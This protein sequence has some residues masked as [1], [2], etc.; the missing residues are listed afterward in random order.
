MAS[1]SPPC[2][3]C[4]ERGGSKEAEKMGA[5]G[6]IWELIQVEKKE[7]R[8]TYVYTVGKTGH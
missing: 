7:F 6:W 2:G 3:F 5:V 8:H 1:L 4:N